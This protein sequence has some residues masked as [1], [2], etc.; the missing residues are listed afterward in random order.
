MAFG[1]LCD[2]MGGANGGEV[3]AQMAVEFAANMLR[4]E[5]RE[6]MSEVSLRSV[7]SSAIAGANALV[8]DKS[9]KDES[10]AGM[11][12]TI[13]VAVHMDETLYVASV[14]DSRVYLFTPEKCVQLTKDHTVV[15]M[16]VDIGEISEED[17]KR[18][19]KR[20]Y[21]TRI[22][23]VFGTAEPDFFVERLR[24]GE[25]ALL[26]SDGLYPYLDPGVTFDLLNRCVDSGSAQPLI[27]VALSAGTTDNITAVIMATEP[28]DKTI[29]RLHDKLTKG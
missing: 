28:I 24:D 18:H 1:I 27:D 21:V 20:H 17:A 3:A 12:T 29:E 2:G 19:P 5:L 23:G 9:Q 26:C 7:L 6:D 4:R 8:Y 15:Q 10:L 11:G 14:G 16:L 13:L 25:I 22:V